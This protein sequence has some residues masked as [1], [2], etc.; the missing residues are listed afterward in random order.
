LDELN[1]IF[2]CVDVDW[3]MKRALYLKASH[4]LMFLQMSRQKQFVAYCGCC[5]KVTEMEGFY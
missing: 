1:C 5:V 2:A 4:W 3:E